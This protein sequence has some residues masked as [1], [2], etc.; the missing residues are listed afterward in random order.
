MK[1]NEIFK[2]VQGEGPWIGRHC[3]FVR[4]VGCNLSCPWCDTKYAK[5]GIEIDVNRLANIIRS[6]KVN[7]VVFT[8]G[9]PT[10]Q[11]EEIYDLMDQFDLINYHFAIETNGTN[12]FNTDRFDQVVVSPKS[13]DSL[14]KWCERDNPNIVVKYV[15]DWQN[16]LSETFKFIKG[17][18][19]TQIYVMPMGITNDE[20]ICGSQALINAI[21]IFHV[22]NICVLS[23]RLH[24][25][26]NVR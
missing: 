18:I 5:T 7:N 1:V 6:E 22:S 15:V 2:S 12:E 9:E 24:I 14:L 26:L 21:D 3:L 17:N 13:T 16:K 25:L 4:L 10:L 8:G 11:I 19:S 23:P 20:C